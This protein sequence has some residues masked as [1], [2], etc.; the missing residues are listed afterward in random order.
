MTI[1]KIKELTLT[2]NQTVT[3]MRDLVDKAEA[4]KRGLTSDEQAKWD[5]GDKAAASLKE[6]IERLQRTYD[7]VHQIDEY[8]KSTGLRSRV[9]GGNDDT[10]VLDDID[11]ED[12][13]EAQR[14]EQDAK[15]QRSFRRAFGTYLR[16][17]MEDLPPEMRK[18]MGT[19]RG[20]VDPKQLR[21]L[22]IG[23][24]AAGGYTVPQDFLAKLFEA[25]KAYG[26]MRGVAQVISSSTGASMPI[27]TESDIANAATIVGEAVQSN[28]SVDATFGQ[29]TLGA[30][31]YRTV[32]KVSMEMLQDS[33]FDINS[34][35][36]RKM[37]IRFGR[38]TNAH[39]TT[40]TGT[41]QPRGL[42]AAS[43]GTAAGKTGTTGQTTTVI[44][45]DLVDLEHSV[46]PEYRANAQFMMHDSSVKV[47]K[48]LKDS[49]GRPIWLPD[50]ASVGGGFPATILGYRYQVNQ[51]MPVMSANAKSIAFGDFQYYLVRD[52]MG[53][54]IVRLTERYADFG[55]VG[56]IGFM[57]TDGVY[58][59]AN[60]PVK[61][62][63]N[64]AT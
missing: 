1:A 25:Q 35:I 15:F 41:G 34:Y 62:Y 24:P 10:T 3:G 29:A 57:R 11:E 26:G 20:Q 54:M 18:I 55:Q 6:R 44:Y 14:R 30:Y 17:G 31:M 53:L 43:G 28:T 63:A 21:D 39:Y 13:A 42:L 49:S 36:P 23:T 45:D 7:L 33:A 2:Y 60:D 51:D 12:A 61:H 4:E 37:G 27:P 40:G 5:E 52:V 58:V 50:Y 47:L 46:D 56:F 9:E 59:N 48:K 22:N 19:A 64:S 8:N 32:V 16:G 38:G